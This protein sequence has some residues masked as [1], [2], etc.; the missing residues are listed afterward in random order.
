MFSL[1]NKKL[2]LFVFLVTFLSVMVVAISFVI[3]ERQKAQLYEQKHHEMDVEIALLAET[4][5]DSLLR[6]DYSEGRY[7]LSRWAQNNTNVT[8]LEAAFLPDTRFYVYRDPDHSNDEIVLERTFGHSGRA[9]NLMLVH[10]TKGI[11]QVL[12]ML[13]QYLMLFAIALIVIA[14]AML[15]YILFRWMIKPM[16]EEITKRTL[17]LAQAKEAAETANKAKSEFLANMSH[18]LRTPLNSI[19]G[20]AEMMRFEIKGPLPK[21]YVE[22][23]DYITGSGRLLLETVNSI[24]DLAKIEAGKMELDQTPA[25]MGNIIEE[26]CSLLNVL[27]LEKGLEIRNETQDL[28]CLMLDEMRMKQ[29]LINI[30]GN[31]IKFTDQGGITIRNQCDDCGHNIIIQD[32]GIGMTPE[33][34]KIALKP[35]IQVHGTSLARRFQGTGL[36]LSLS[37]QILELHGGEL[38]VESREGH[39]TTVTLS[40]PPELRI[41]CNDNM[42]KP[43]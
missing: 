9:V 16:E 21:T 43:A 7:L 3:Y 29:V 33:Q 36:G 31:A 38:I 26:V 10:D 24:L 32:T 12:V 39:G 18:E 22:Y 20:F 2:L 19:I 25:Y 28:H 34:V 6:H 15:W 1:A 37:R 13:A 11:E 35:F 30:I 23:T 42:K 4:L 8:K 41:D 17:Q 40:L 5:K 27:A 14:S